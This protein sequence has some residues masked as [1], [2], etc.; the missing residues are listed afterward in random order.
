MKIIVKQKID[1]SKFSF[2]ISIVA[3]S[4]ELIYFKELGEPFLNIANVNEPTKLVKLY[5]DTPI[6]I[7]S[8]YQEILIAHKN[9]LVERIKNAVDDLKVRYKALVIQDEIIEF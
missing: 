4:I 8:D 6:T 9:L 5:S 1:E 3:N 7:T 2:I